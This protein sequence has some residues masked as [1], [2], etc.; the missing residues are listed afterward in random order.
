MGDINAKFRNNYSENRQWVIWDLGR[1]SGSPPVVF[2]GYLDSG[3]E[4]DWILLSDKGDVMYQ[5][6]TDGAQTHPMTVNDGDT[7]NMD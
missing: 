3:A 6:P 4:T 1:D 5:R 2:D 7:V